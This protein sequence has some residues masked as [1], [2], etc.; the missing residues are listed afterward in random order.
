MPGRHGGGIRGLVFLQLQGTVAPV[1][2]FRLGFIEK[3]RKV[4]L[5]WL[6]F[7]GQGLSFSS[8]TTAV[9]VR[10]RAGRLR[11]STAKPTRFGGWRT[12]LLPFRGTRRRVLK[13]DTLASVRPAG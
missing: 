7:S 12:L 10:A 1:G 9:R 6:D 13:V 2:L 3:G 5:L 11:T 8:S 4:A